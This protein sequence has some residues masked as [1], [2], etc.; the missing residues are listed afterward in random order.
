MRTDILKATLKKAAIALGVILLGVGSSQGQSVGLTAAPATTTLPDGQII[1]MWGYSCGTTAGGATCSALNASGGW[2]PVLITTAPGNLTINLTNGL[3]FPVS[4]GSPNNIPTSLVIVGQ[5]GGGLGAKPTR[6]TSPVHPPQGATWPI[7]GDNSGPVFNPPAQA[8]RVES[9]AT[10]VATG[11]TTALNWTGLRPG[12]YLIESGTHPSIQGPMGLYGVLV[13]TDK[14]TTPATAYPGITYSADVP[15]LLSEIDP[16]QNRAVAA[17]VISAGFS[18]TATQNLKLADSVNSIAV[19]AGGSGYTSTPT[20]TIDSP[21]VGGTQATATAVIE[22]NPANS[23][24]GQ[25]T[26]IDVTDGGSGYKANPNVTISGGGGSGA[27]ATSGLLLAGGDRC[28]GAGAC[29][30]PAV[31]YDPRYYLINGSAFDRTSPAKSQFS[32]ATPVAAT[33]PKILVRFVNAGLR[34]HIPSIVGAV[35]DDSSSGSTKVVP[36][37]ALIAEDGNPLPGNHRVQ[38]EV[39]LVAGKTYDVLINAPASGAPALPVFD[40][41]LSLSTNN[42]RDGGMQ[43]YISVNGG[44]LPAV[45]ITAAAH[46]DHYYLIPGNTLT[47][48]DPS[49]GVLANDVGVYGAKV[50]GSTPAGLTTFNADGTFTYSGAVPATFNY[51]GNTGSSCALVTIGA[52]DG[53]LINGKACQGGAP[54]AGDDSYTSAVSSKLQVSPPGIL[55]NDSDPDGHPLSVLNPGSITAGGV[56]LKVNADGSFVATRSATTADAVVTFQYQAV[57]SQNTQSAP[58][59][60]TMTFKGRSGLTVTVQDAQSKAQINDYRWIIEEDRTIT[61][62]PNSQVNTGGTVPTI[63]TNFHTSHMPV[64]AS[65]CVGDIACES[66]QKMQGQDVVCDQGN[67]VCHPGTKKD[68]LDPGDVHLDPAKHYFISVLPGDGADG[69]NSGAGGPVPVDPNK[70]DGAQRPFDISKDCTFAVGSGNC[71]HTM[72]GSP[73]APNQTSVVVNVE[74]TPLPTAKISVFVFEDDNPLNGENDAGGGVDIL[75][76]NE[77]GLGGFAITLLDQAGGLGDST[78]QLTY[79]MFNMPVS[80]A[81]A[82]TPDPAHPGNDACPIS[83]NN[84]GLVGMIVT[85]PKFESDGTTLSPLAG[86]AVIANL[87]PGLYEVVATPGADRIARGEEWLQTNSLDGTKPLEAFIKAGEPSYFQEFG[88][89]GFHVSLGFANP[90]IINGRHNSVCAGKSCTNIVKGH[91][92][93]TRISRSP[94]ERLYSSG[95]YDSFGFTQCYVSLGDPDEEDF[96]FT[97][98]D[99]QGNFSFDRVPDGTWRITVFDQ[100][101]DLLVDGLATPVAVSGGQ[102]FDMHDVPIQQWRTNI[103]TRTYLDQD[104]NGVSGDTEPGLPLVATNIRYRDGSFAN[105]NNTDLNG[106]AGFNEVFPYFNWVVLEA[107][108]TR[109]KQT[110]VHVV[111]DAGG[112]ADGAGGGSS[113]IADH[114][115]N[116]IETNHLPPALRVPGAVYCNDAD[117]TSRGGDASTGRID[118]PWATTEAWQG[119]IG[120]NEFVEFGKKPYAEGENGGIRGHVIYMSTRPFD[121]PSLLLQLSWT[122]GVPN[123][124]MNLYQEGTAP[125][126]TSSLKLVDTTQTTSWDDWAQ[127]FRSDGIPNMNCPGQDSTSPF[128][129]TLKDSQQYLNPG[130]ALPNDSQFKC[131]DGLHMFNQVQPAPYDGMYSFPSVTSR[132]PVTGYPTGTNCSICSDNPTGDHTKMLPAGKYVVEVVIPPG[133]ELVKEEDK[134][135]LIGD[136]YI[137][138]V[139]QQFGGLGSV[140]IM[141]DQAA[142]AENYNPNNPQ[143]QTANLGAQPRHEGDTGSIETFWPCVGDKRIVPDYIS[144]FPQSQ[145]VSPF[146]GAS[147]NLCDRKEVTLEDQM[148]VLA[149]FYVFS[150]TH[151]ASHYT[152]IITDDFASEFDPFSPQFGEKFAVPNLPIS[153]KDFNGVEI[154]RTYTDQ[155]GYYN[156]MNYSTWEV[157][158]PNPTGYAPTMMVACMNDPGPI[159]GPGGTL[160]TDPA[161]N[162]NYSQFCYELPFMPGQT[163]YLDTP[164]VPTAAFAEGYNPPD[165]AYPNA[166]PAIREVDGDSFGPW[167]GAAK[168]TVASISLT[169]SGGGY[170]SRPTLTLNGGGGSGA[171]ATVNDLTVTSLT[172]GNRGNGYSSIPTVNFGN[173]GGGSGAAAVVNDLRLVGINNFTCTNTGT[174]RCSNFGSHPAVSITGGGGVGAS[175]TATKNGSTISFSV[176]PGSGYTSRPTVTVTRSDATVLTL[177]AGN[178]RMGVNTLTLTAG[179]AGYTSAPSVTIS[180]PGFGNGNARATANLSMS[181]NSVS[182]TNN[183]SGYTSAP[184]PN[185]SGGGGSGAAASTALG[186]SNQTLTIY[187]LGDQQVLNNAYSGPQA[188]SAPFNQRKITRHYGFGDVQ[189]SGSVTIGGLTATVNSWSDSQITITP[190]ANLPVCARSYN[191]G[192]TSGQALATFGRCGQLVVAAGNG[193]KSIDAVTVTIGGKAPTYVNNENPSNHAIQ[194]AIDAASPGDLI[195]LG[196]GSYSEMVLMWKPV[197]LQGVGAPSVTINANTHPSGRLDPWRHQVTCLFGLALNGQPISGS[198]PYD[199]NPDNPMVCPANQQFQVDRIPLEGIV[200]WDTTTNGNLAELLQEPT[201]MGAY[202]GAGITVLAKGAR[203]PAGSDAF[204][205]G[206]ESDFPAGTE[207]LTNSSRDCNEFH[208]NFQC[209]PARIDGIGITNS[210]QGGGG[211]FIHGWGHYMEISNDRLFANAG[212]LSGAINVGQGEFPDPTIAGNGQ[213][214]GYGFNT[215]VWVHNNSITGNTSYGDELFSSTPSAAGGITFCTGADY[216]QFNFNWL[217]GN[218]SSGDGGGLVHSGFIYNGNISNNWILFNQSANPT[219]PTNGGGIA[220]IGASPDR[221]LPDGTECGSTND[222]DCPPGLSEGTGPGLTI[223]ANL[224]L[225]NTAESG[226]GGGIRLQGVNGQDVGRTPLQPGFWNSV[227]LTNNI[228]ANNVAGW[229]GGGVSLE[230]A[231]KVQFVNNTIIA[232]DSTASAGILFN[233]I[234]APLSSSPVAGCDPQTGIGCVLHSTPQTAG[235]VTMA[236]TTNLTSSLPGTILCPAGNSSGTGLV[237]PIPNGD[238]RRVSYP[239]LVSNLFWQNRAFNIT[240]GDPSATNPLLDQQNTVTLVPQLNQNATGACPSGASYWDIGVRGDTGPANHGS[241]FTLNPRSSILSDASD[242]SSSGSGNLGSDPAVARQYCNGSRVPTENGGLG[243]DVPPGIADAQVPNPVFS[244]T[245]AATVDEGNNW[246]NMAY[247]PLSLFNPAGGLMGNY[248]ITTNSPAKDAVP[249]AVSSLVGPPRDFFGTSR[250]QGTRFD[251]GAV[252]FVASSGPAVSLTPVAGTTFAQTTPNGVASTL[253]FNLSNAGP[254]TFTISSITVGAAPFSRVTSGVPNDCGAS[255]A[256]GASCTIRGAFQPTTTGMFNGTVTVTGTSGAAAVAVNGSPL[257]ISGTAV[258]NTTPP[259][260]VSLAAVS[261]TTFPQTGVGSSATLDFTLSNAGP[262]A[263]SIGSANV[264]AAPFSR[265]T[266]GVTNNCGTTLAAGF[267]CTI[268]AAFQPTAGGTF[269]GTVDVSGTG[270]GGTLVTVSGSPI[271]ISGTALQAV[272]GFTVPANMTTTPGTNATKTGTVTITNTGN[273]PL[274]LTAAPT[275]AKSSGLGTGTPSITGGT[276]IS[277]TVVA[278][279]GGTCTLTVQ[280]APT[281]G[282]LGRQTANL[283]VTLTDTGAATPTQS[284]QTFPAN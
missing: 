125:D 42:Q 219:I 91:V 96:A 121:D 148:S 225:G 98:C 25:V 163:S 7:A 174:N 87:Y 261:S 106:F 5:V 166:T 176:T 214:L 264:G 134:N 202:E 108:T 275:I 27:T 223:D 11:A 24:Y 183:G 40:R 122:P 240:V 270:P 81:L 104:G 245:P 43:G 35:T 78:G 61:L 231:L 171:T 105:F 75:A 254:G 55:A 6:T 242:Y 268:H 90:A 119:F 193:K 50:S 204:G 210:S 100:W 140:F 188:T 126:G 89:A 30:P 227:T 19:T 208:S 197:R 283:S 70:P 274:T 250:P 173:G 248:S 177:T 132:D 23:L 71:G 266:A 47:V 164:V 118:P 44:G 123:V 109:Y 51:C 144:L 201:L 203:F 159:P 86:Q 262:G 224:I 228:I 168:G 127:G 195:M 3:S 12:T 26:E 53:I 69:F 120:N 269:N 154:S 85:C 226:S 167:V 220:V 77:P 199:S 158:P 17:A 68:A 46:D 243:Y 276:C 216:Y 115:A 255:L 150:S 189:G 238:C 212:T 175:A 241:G 260:V 257:A 185:F 32:A 74:P 110:G 56:T 196:A 10:E 28:G 178:V 282:F 141:P 67:G 179:G 251:I 207:I 239:L 273:G 172:L 94:D 253:N 21:P 160:I 54:V 187:A 256:A 59:T 20:V 247:G 129:F 88:P 103:N 41:Q 233:T 31:N 99:D 213:Q 145:E 259:P 133:Y 22:T 16:T 45:G 4:G 58:A 222:Q 102:T 143:N 232:N 169:S 156:G 116:T 52:C 198:N 13:V 258:V 8:D 151:V 277:G 142:V 95:S 111:Y 236:N 161:F 153:F 18:E 209:A 157:N 97:K 49:K 139:T 29:Y 272:V 190:P 162:P 235:L 113:T 36:G 192:F 184:T 34:A 200:G 230:D 284:S 218:L 279:S 37:F 263:F 246:V 149:K 80:N 38:S 112:P 229:D 57:N 180:S 117:C 64:I 211:I 66:G 221:T 182:L 205:T 271:A 249:L 76:P 79:D 252:E 217:C 60:V 265:V 234:G 93:T 181:I 63:G 101:N 1:P 147:R 130:I 244:L 281:G 15:L 137:A 39:L 124:T 146:A 136:N 280:W 155:W 114:L 194:Q 131:Y 62:D 48:S 107:D 186:T 2:S 138:P 73:I 84:D 215:N 128:F 65:G 9:F 33:N 152:G 165:C 135:I 278:A 191:A 92:T 14:T 267:N 82:G 83:H 72:G 206:A 237:F 170:T